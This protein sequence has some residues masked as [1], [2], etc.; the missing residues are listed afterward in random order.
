M[1]R[2][3]RV[4]RVK[5]GSLKRSDLAALVDRAEVA[6]ADHT[7]AAR[8]T[9]V[10]SI[11][12]AYWHAD[13]H[14]ASLPEYK[15]PAIRACSRPLRLNHLQHS[16]KRFRQR[17]RFQRHAINVDMHKMPLRD[18]VIYTFAKQRHFIAHTRIADAR[19]A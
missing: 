3:I 10:A 12:T 9:A 15:C 8:V 13:R 16:R 11:S 18:S 5:T 14:L 2:N 1:A 17:L 4:R 19:D 7:E 6:A